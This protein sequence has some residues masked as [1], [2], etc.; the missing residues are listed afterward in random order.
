MISFK[1]SDTVIAKPLK[2]ASVVRQGP[3]A[4]TGGMRPSVFFVERKSL[5]SEIP[6]FVKC[7]KYNVA[8]MQQGIHLVYSDRVSIVDALYFKFTLGLTVLARTN[9]SSCTN[10]YT[11]DTRAIANSVIKPYFIAVNN[12]D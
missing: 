6:F 9:K 8:V 7:V 4:I 2:G 5:A 3:F 12:R 11:T 1:E 10:D